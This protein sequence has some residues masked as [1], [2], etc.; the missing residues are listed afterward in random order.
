MKGLSVI[1]ILLLATALSLAQSPP[2]WVNMG[3]LQDAYGVKDFVQLPWSKQTILSCGYDRAGYYHAS[4][5]KSTDLGNSW[6]YKFWPGSSYDYFQQIRVDSANYRVWAIGYF[7]DDNLED[8]LYYTIDDGEN[9]TGVDYPDNITS[10]GHGSAVAILNGNV[11]Y[12]GFYDNASSLKFYRYKTSDSN[13]A[14]WAWEYIYTFDN[15]DAITSFKTEGDYLYIFVR[16]LARDAYRIYKLNDKTK[17]ISLLSTVNLNYVHEAIKKNSDY[18]VAGDSTYI[19]RIYK[20][21]DMIHWNKIV[22]WTGSGGATVMTVNFY[23]DTL[24]AGLWGPSDANYYVYKSTDFGSSWSGCFSPAAIEIVYAIRN[25]NSELWLSSGWDYGDIFK[26]TWNVQKGGK[27]YYGPTYVYDAKVHGDYIYYTTNYDHGELYRTGLSTGSNR[28][29]PFADASKG[30]SLEWDSDTLY[31]ALDGGNLIKKSSDDGSSWDDTFMPQG[32][33]D[34]LAIKKFSDGKLFIGT[35]NYGD[36]FEATNRYQT[37]GSY[38]YG[39]TEVYQAKTH[40]DK[41]YFTTNY[42]NGEIYTLD[43]SENPVVWKNFSDA[44]FA[45]DIEWQGDTI[46]VAL[47]S[48]NL[49]KKST[50]GGSSWDDTFKPQGATHVLSIFNTSD[51]NLLSG[52]DWYGDVYIA[53]NRYETGGSY[54][55]G[56]TYVY[57]TQFCGSNGYIATNY[58]NG[59]IWKTE[60]DGA[61]WSN[62]TKYYQP[63]QKVYS[64]VVFGN[65]MYAGTDYNGDV[66]KSEDSGQN[67]SVTGDLTNAT[68]VLGLHLSSDV[69]RNKL[70]AGTDWNGDVFLSDK[71]VMTLEA[72]EI[73][74]EPHYTQGTNNTVYCRNNGSDSYQFE[75]ASDSSFTDILKRS[76]SV[77]D[78]FYTFTNLNDGITYYYRAYGKSCSYS[79]KASAK[80]FS[81]QDSKAPS[82]FSESPVHGSWINND[83][84]EI[85]INLKDDG[86]GVDTTSI[87]MSLDSL[88]IQPQVITQNQVIYTPMYALAQN[89]HRISVRA[90]D[91]FAQESE[92]SW[93][94]A[95]DVE[96]PSVPLLISPADSSIVASQTITFHWD[97]SKDSISGLKHYLLEY[98]TEPNFAKDVDTV[99]TIQTNYS[100]KLIDTTYFWM[101]TAVDS[102]GNVTRSGSRTLIVDANPPALPHLQTP[103]KGI[104][105]NASDVLF[106]WDQVSKPADNVLAKQHSIVSTAVSYAIQVSKGSSIIIDDTVDVNEYQAHLGEGKYYWKID[107]FDQAKNESG[108]TPV[109]SFGIDFTSPVV[110]SI[111]VLKDTSNYFGPFEVNAVVHDPIGE[112]DTTL[113]L[114]R[115]DSALFDTTAMQFEN[116]VY[117]G[118]IPKIDSTD[119]KISYYVLTMD[120]VGL[121][122]VSDTISFST[123]VTGIEDITANIPDKFEIKNPWPNPTNGGMRLL[124]GL[125]KSLKVKIEIYN[126]LGQRLWLMEKAYPMGWHKI[127]LPENFPSGQYFI[128]VSS[129]LG[130][131]TVKGVIIK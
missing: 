46:Y 37:G 52:T 99:V 117:R 5:W 15:A 45:T 86:I 19:A 124:F 16:N 57:D 4:I 88:S 118:S 53:T 84:P 38:I 128:K 7:G 10:V 33:S 114:Y 42:T 101:V 67:W 35:D 2:G 103:I 112:I 104:W 25:V 69:Q 26:A 56:P 58:D 41:T 77:S 119:H 34:A 122:A 100:A 92:Y 94:F 78:T 32:A 87:T 105:L 74:Q 70:F 30:Y 49:I 82:F 17:Q 72:P 97:A 126:I 120:K 123:T 47:D 62:L 13:P 48:P 108:W 76:P 73:V 63:W 29:T 75:V 61:N 109:D 110:D 36:V 66:Y 60:D 79:S 115:F 129:Q 3:N 111:T 131:R 31:I 18:Y 107:A 54:I 20:S 27:Y 89:W 21:S 85:A 80:T 81:I 106:M 95:V 90:K 68:E 9:W 113:L 116:G 71:E 22:E 65:T 91:Y 102:A 55:Y 1:Y 98:T 44:S 28:I 39:P 59:E 130:M 43:N 121:S 40:Q 8:A 51:N 83:K 50:D 125:P 11:Y 127:Q 14:N 64:L 24:F 12:G 23:G 96:N 6:E 93:R